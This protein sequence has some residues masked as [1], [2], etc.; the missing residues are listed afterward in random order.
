MVILP[1]VGLLLVVLAGNYD[2][3]QAYEVPVGVLVDVLLPSL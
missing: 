3:P 2:I 1:R